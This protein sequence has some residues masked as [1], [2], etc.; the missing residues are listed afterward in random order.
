M[1]T[2][3]SQPHDAHGEHGH[4]DHAQPKCLAHHFETPQQQFDSGKLGVWLF[5]TTEILL[6]SGLFCAYAVYRANHPEIFEF[7][8]YYLNKWYGALNTI[9]LI[10][11]SFTMAWAVRS[12]QMGTRRLTTILLAI[13][14]GCGFIFMGIK[15]I[16]Y[17][18]K[19]REAL[20]PGRNYNPTEMPGA[21]SEAKT[22][23]QAA[24][25]EHA[26]MGSGSEKH[27]QA[28][29]MDARNEPAGVN[30]AEPHAAA[31]TAP[32]T[33]PAA[34]GAPVVDANASVASVAAPATRR[35]ESGF[36]VEQSV[37]ARAATGP[38]GVDRRWSES[39]PSRFAVH[40]PAAAGDEA[41]GPEPP[42]THIFFGIYFL[43]TG[44]HGIHVLA[45]MALIGWCLL[46]NQRGDFGPDYFSPV[47]FVGLY[48]HIVDLVWI[49]LFPLLY[50]IGHSA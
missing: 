26:G 35:A 22:Q 1:T 28:P 7:A 2:T 12:S 21:H 4:G 23:A 34:G 3:A 27:A 46:R 41:V 47:D 50:L 10:F 30:P 15:A 38:E 11:S 13:T 36:L 31:G 20:L 19:W 29:K 24:P 32:A 39:D 37:I 48:W 40:A 5:L 8:H 17:T 6:F 16:E 25:G 9:V 42:N 43:M 14:I 18:D 33:A 44:L 45:G 49:F